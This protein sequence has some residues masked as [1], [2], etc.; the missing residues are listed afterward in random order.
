M[1]EIAVGDQVRLRTFGSTGV[2]ESIK[3][4]TAEVR[5]G[6][7][8]LR[9]KLDNL[10]LVSNAPQESPPAKRGA[11]LQQAASRGTE[12]RL[13]DAGEAPGM[14]LNLIGRTT[15]EAVD[16]IDPF[17]DEAYLHSLGRVR[18]IHGHGTGALRRAVHNF[19]K[20]HPHVANF[21]QAPPEQ[22]GAGATIVELKQ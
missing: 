11:R 2:V 12:V 18:I 7:V 9:E 8:R 13:R 1:R 15:D 3:R 16:V 21:A 10:E 17:L 22:G 14:E 5:A 4:D 20:N 19:L 6:A